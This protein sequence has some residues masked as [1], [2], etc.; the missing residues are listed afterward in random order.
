MKIRESMRSSFKSL[1]HN[2]MRSFLTMLGVIIGVFSVVMLTSIGEGVKLQVTAEV[3]S[4]G[5]NLLYV[6]PGKVAIKPLNGKSKLGIKMSELSQ[7]KSSLAYEDAL[8]LKHQKYIAAVTGV[9]NGV[10]KLDSLNLWVSTTGV[11][12][13][14]NKIRNLKLTTGRFINKSECATKA[15][16]AVIGDEANKELFNSK[17]SI[18]KGFTLNGK[19]YRVVGVLQYK[20]PE[21]FGPRGEDINVEIFLPV[22]EM[23]RRSVDKN[24]D[25]IIVKATAA[26]SVKLAEQKIKNILTSRHRAEDF[27]ILKQQDMLDAINNILGILTAALGGIAAISL[28]VGGIG[29]MNIMLVSVAERTREIGIRK[30]I[31]AK[32]RDILIQFL[33]EAVVLSIAGGLV[34]LIIGMIGSRLLPK[35]FP[36][37]HTA[38]SVPASIIALLFA[39]LVGGFFGV[40]PAT[41]AADLNPIEALRNE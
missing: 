39:F 24:I 18:G 26:K 37:I 21:N 7:N 9:Y 23:L 14:F 17:K 12:E 29:I 22:T 4:L 3:E 27:S 35:L 10:D 16:V 2:R 38:I 5:A 11:D 40:Y 8:A 15:A 41:K 34:G 13:D 31:G 32:R 28:V 1:S 6:L 25:R 30:A 20:K 19:T 33:I 36:I